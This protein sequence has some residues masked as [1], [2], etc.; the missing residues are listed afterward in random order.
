MRFYGTHVKGMCPKLYPI[1][2][3]MEEESHKTVTSSASSLF[4]CSLSA[5]WIDLLLCRGE[6]PASFVINVG[7]SPG[8]DRANEKSLSQVVLLPPPLGKKLITLRRGTVINNGACT[9]LGSLVVTWFL[10]ECRWHTRRNSWD[11]IGWIRT[12][13]VID[14]PHWLELQYKAN[15]SVGASCELWNVIKC[16]YATVSL[17]EGDH[18]R[19]GRR[20][21]R[22]GGACWT[23]N[24]TVSTLNYSCL[25][26]LPLTAIHPS[27]VTQCRWW[28][29]WNS[30]LLPGRLPGEVKS[31]M[32]E[33]LSGWM[34]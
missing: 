19:T 17:A 13:R 5:Q 18:R 6:K 30:W 15:E 11:A 25:S 26:C 27:G 7:M 3:M 23:G 20:R 33:C 10:L 34:K 4:A 16:H 2:F 31:L 32:C 24:L 9:R 1:L 22:T 28:W 8:P 12:W 14:S 21:R 29:W